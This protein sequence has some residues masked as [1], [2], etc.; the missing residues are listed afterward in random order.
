M[1]LAYKITIINFLKNS[2][3]LMASASQNS[4]AK[5]PVPSFSRSLIAKKLG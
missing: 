5:A 3:E 2:L 1:F 4:G